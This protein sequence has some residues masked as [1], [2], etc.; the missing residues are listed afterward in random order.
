MS[1]WETG[2]SVS[3]WGWMKAGLTGIWQCR[4]V[5]A[6]SVCGNQ[7]LPSS[8]RWPP[9]YPQ[10]YVKP[11]RGQLFTWKLYEHCNRRGC[12]VSPAPLAV[13]RQGGIAPPLS[14]N[15]VLCSLNGC[16]SFTPISERNIM[17]LKVELLSYDR[18]AVRRI[19]YSVAIDITSRV[20]ASS[21]FEP[22]IFK[23]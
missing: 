11:W 8:L 23:C 20:L 22:A 10:S 13:H 6:P 21:F 18:P 17:H 19:N 3:Q 12:W 14:S 9:K 1:L 4:E 2:C 5:L 16:C 15:T 7:R